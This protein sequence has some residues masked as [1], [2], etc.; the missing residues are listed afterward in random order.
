MKILHI[1]TSL[2][3]GGAER[4]VADLCPCLQKTGDE[5]SVLL[6]DGTR[7]ALYDQLEQAGTPIETLSKGWRAMRNP[8]LLPRLFRYLKGNAFDIVH[9]HNAEDP[10]HIEG[11][12][13]QSWYV[14][15]CRAGDTE[16]ST[17]TVPDKL[18]YTLSGDNYSG[19]VVT[20]TASE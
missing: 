5:I 18:S 15:Y 11:D 13:G 17:L 14:Y 10:L 7:T 8:F 9:T 2:R 12:N 19:F 20:V 1:I 3:T 4:I 6:L 16:T